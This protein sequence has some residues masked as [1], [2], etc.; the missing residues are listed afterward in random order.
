MAT[1]RPWET[2]PHPTPGVRAARNAGRQAAVMVRRHRLAHV[3]RID[4]AASGPPIDAAVRRWWSGWQR[5]A[6]LPVGLLVL[7]GNGRL[8]LFTASAAPEA[9]RGCAAP[10]KRPWGRAR[11]GCACSRCR[12]RRGRGRQPTR[13]RARPDC[14]CRPRRRGIGAVATATCSRGADG[15]P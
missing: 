9:Q 6:A 8:W 10:W 14:S 4:L 11:Q 13:R 12:C 15:G 5:R 7:G 2:L 1:V 3:T